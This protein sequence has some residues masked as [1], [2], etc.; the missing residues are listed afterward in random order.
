MKVVT[1]DELWFI[2]IDK[3][4]VGIG[5]MAVLNNG[6]S[7][8]ANIASAVPVGTIMQIESVIG[9]ESWIVEVT[10]VTQVTQDTPWLLKLSKQGNAERSFSVLPRWLSYRVVSYLLFRPDAE[11]GSLLDA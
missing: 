11:P 1:A 5:R 2:Y 9:T 4:F 3:I 6:M 10:E 8:N 7:V